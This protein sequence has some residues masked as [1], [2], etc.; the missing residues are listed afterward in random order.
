MVIWSQ[1]AVADLRSIHDFIARDSHYYAKKVVHD[2]RE[3]V[4]E[5]NGLPKMGRMVP[6]LNE[7]AVRELL[8]YSYRIIYEIKG[9]EI[10]VLAVVHQ[11]KNLKDEKIP[12]ES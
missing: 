3:L 7:E 12:R 11:R 1:Q 5:L 6:E 8:L 4:D 2:I 9:E 10:F